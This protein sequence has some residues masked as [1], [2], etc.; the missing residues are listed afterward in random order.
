[1]AFALGLYLLGIG[2][3]FFSPE[4][5]LGA[6][7]IL[8]ILVLHICEL[9]TALQIGRNKNLSDAR[10]WLMCLAFGYTWWLPL[11]IGLFDS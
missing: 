7:L 3:L 5:W 2:L 11:K 9:K 1:M 4:P 8:G 10:I 6:V